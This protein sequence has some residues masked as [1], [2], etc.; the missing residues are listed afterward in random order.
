MIAIEFAVP[1]E[2]R[3]VDSTGRELP[4]A[5]RQPAVVLNDT[6]GPALRLI[7]S[8]RADAG[9]VAASITP[10]QRLALE[11][12]RLR[13]V[14]VLRLTEVRASQHRIVELGDVER[15]RIER[16]LHDGAQQRLVA[17]TMQLSSARQRSGSAGAGPMAAGEAH[18]KRALAGLRELSHNS[19]AAVLTAEGLGAAI[20]DLVATSS[21]RIDLQHTF[22]E[23]KLS[24][25]VQ[26][27]A[28]LTIR[29]ALDNVAAHAGVAHARVTIVETGGALVVSIVDRGRGGA[30]MGIGLTA[31]AD[32]VGALGGHLLLTSTPAGGTTLTAQLPCG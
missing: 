10:A 15:R 32:R 12:A 30:C 20:D 31:V 6:D 21:L 23:S 5:E 4:P 28:Y 29:A 2:H 9:H 17:V 26:T 8:Q 22:L 3:W 14:G 1:H 24:G 25:P 19:L 16:D 11:N 27:T 7:L 13:A 18:V